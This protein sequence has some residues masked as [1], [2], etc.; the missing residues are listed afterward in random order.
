MR[1]REVIDALVTLGDMEAD[2][3]VNEEC[4]IMPVN[5]IWRSEFTIPRTTESGIVLPGFVWVIQ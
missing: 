4:G 2:L 5:G 1:I 3:Y